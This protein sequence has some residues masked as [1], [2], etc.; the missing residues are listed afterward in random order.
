MMPARTQRMRQ[1]PTTLLGIIWWASFGAVRDFVWDDLRHGVLSLRGLSRGTRTL[2]WLGFGLLAAVL[3][4]LIANDL[5]RQQFPLAA[6]PNAVAGRG[7]LLPI[8]LVPATLFLVAV[9]WAFALTGALH[10]HPLGR[11]GVSLLYAA[12]AVGWNGQAVITRSVEWVIGWGAIPLVLVFFLLRWRGAPRPIPEFIVLLLLVSATLVTAQTQ[13]AE[14]WKLTG[15]ALLLGHLNGEVLSLTLLIMPLLLLVGMGFADFTRQVA[16]WTVEIAEG[17]LPAWFPRVLLL[18]FVTWRLRTVTLEAFARV[19]STSPE[20]ALR[21]YVGALGVPLLVGLGWLLVQS[22]PRLV[23]LV[24]SRWPKRAVV[25][26]QTT[27]VP[28]VP[29]ADAVAE[30][31]DRHALLLIVIY[32]GLQVLSFALYIFSVP[33]GSLRLGPPD[34]VATQTGAVIHFLNAEGMTLGW[35]LMIDMLAIVLGVTLHRQRAVALYLVVFGLVDAYGLLAAPNRLFS[36]FAPQNASAALVD[37]WWVLLFTVVG[38]AWLVR[39]RLT[40]ERVSR[41]LFLLLVTWLLRQTDFIS[42]RFSPFFGSAGVSFIAFG[43]AWDALT[44]GAW[45]NQST[46][47][48]P[49][50]SRIFLYLGYTLLTVTV[51]NWAL[52]VHDLTAL[53]RLTGEAGFDGL[54]RFGRPMLYAVF[55]VTLAAPARGSPAPRDQDETPDDDLLNAPPV[56]EDEPLIRKLPG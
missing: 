49:R 12:M 27:V 5:L 47:G 46:H 51:V 23:G 54:Q 35:R 9:A 30:A 22:G 53:S 17:R 36:A 44:I 34:L 39:G 32:A 18:A 31:A 13:G 7:S 52:S 26:T 14:T 38:V 40:N 48:L 16:T 2:I 41:L 10:C 24:H 1:M 11:I 3:V 45:A 21:S 25:G 20:V 56:D 29:T 43:L 37:F 55:A 15:V 28:P 50:L 33:I 42:N 4:L 6:L 19:A 8:A